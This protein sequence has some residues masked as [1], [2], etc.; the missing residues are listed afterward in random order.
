[1]HRWL[2]LILLPLTAWI[3]LPLAACSPDYPLDRPGTGS[4]PPDNLGS[5]AENLRAMVADPNDLAAG[6]SEDGSAGN[7]AAPP[8]RKLLSGQRPALPVIS[9][10][11]LGSTGAQT[12]A[13]PGEGGAGGSVQQQ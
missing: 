1:M 5:N 10:T 3:L 11:P 6:V 8:V 4:L 13:S 12:S 2:R 7:Q 9:A